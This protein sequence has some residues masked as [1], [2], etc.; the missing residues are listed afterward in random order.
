MRR[1]Y[2][3]HVRKLF[4]I[5]IWRWSSFTFKQYLVWIWASCQKSQRVVRMYL[6][7]WQSSDIIRCAVCV[8]YIALSMTT[9]V[10]TLILI[11]TVF[12]RILNILRMFEKHLFLGVS[13]LLLCVALTFGVIITPFWC[14]MYCLHF[15]LFLP[16]GPRW[17][18]WQRLPRWRMVGW[19]MSP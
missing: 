8:V 14:Y 12:V 16:L 6:A 11:S 10:N 4:F 9:T 2:F 19:F 3:I 7:R 17:R 13:G 1:P 5:G 18:I 15:A